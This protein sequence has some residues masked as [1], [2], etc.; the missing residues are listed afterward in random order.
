MQGLMKFHPLLLKIL[1]KQNITD[2]Q[3]E[4]SIPAHK[5]FAGGRGGGGGEWWEP[6]YL[7]NPPYLILSG[8]THY[9]LAKKILIFLILF[10]K[11]SKWHH[12]YT[13]IDKARQ[14]KESPVF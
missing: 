12:I 8:V 1:I 11:F 2:G 9:T 7:A 3:R 14:H 5:E 10:P 6:Q 13:L 4:N